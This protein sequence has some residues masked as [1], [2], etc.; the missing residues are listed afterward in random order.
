MSDFSVAAAD[1]LEPERV[2]EHLYSIDTRGYSIITGFLGDGACDALRSRLAE[3]LEAYRPLPG[4][5]RSADDRYLL[6]DLLARE[7]VFARLLEDPRLQQLISPLLGEHWI[8]YAFTSSSLPPHG[9]N[10]GRRVHLDSARFAPLYAFNIGVIWA[11]DPF[12]SENGATEV[13]PGSQHSGAVAPARYFEENCA[14]ITCGRGDLI[15]F[16][17]RLL[18]RS[19][20][21]RSGEWRHALTM[22]C[23]RSFMKQRM[24]WVRMIPPAIAEPLN[25]QAR[26][27]LGYDTRLP[28]SL[29]ELYLPDDRRLYKPNQG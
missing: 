7:L 4:N 15:V 23:C 26:R 8:M 12:T 1:L 22:N 28:T 21:N 18:H 2:A 16:H 11:L 17:A 5:Q 3:S 10:Y 24:D 14:Q 6:H 9:T 27:L 13:L 19:G 20:E 29:E 25:S